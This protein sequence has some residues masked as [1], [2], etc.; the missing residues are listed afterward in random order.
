MSAISRRVF[1]KA[2]GAAAATIPAAADAATTD[3]AQRPGAATKPAAAPARYAFFN[4]QEAAFIEAAVERLIPTDETGPG[5]REAGVAQY[6][7]LQLAGAWGAGE[8]LYRQGPFFPGEPTQ[9][10]QLPFTPAQLFRNALRGVVADVQSKHGGTFDK[11]SA[12]DQDT[13]LTALQKRTDALNGV[14]ASVF[15]ASLLE[16]AI[17]GFFCDPVYGGNR[18]MV[19]WKLV[20]FPGAYANYYPYVG[21]NVAFTRPPVSLAEDAHGHVTVNP[22]RSAEASPPRASAAKGK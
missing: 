1:L 20:G 8:R 11:L 4:A 10:Y 14:P 9:G 2:A 18:D 21:E 7:D 22:K 19:G 3:T 16:M 17:E 5:A 6:I 13:Y 12:G 15:F